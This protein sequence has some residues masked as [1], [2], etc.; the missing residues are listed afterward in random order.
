MKGLQSFGVLGLV[1]AV[2]SVGHA[3]IKSSDFT[4]PAYPQGTFNLA[5]AYP[6]TVGTYASSGI[7]PSQTWG[8]TTASQPLTQGAASGILSLKRT[9]D[10]V[11][12]ANSFVVIPSGQRPPCSIQ[13]Y[14][15]IKEV[16]G[17]YKCP[18]V[19]G[20]PHFDTKNNLTPYRYYQFGA[21][22]RTWWSLSFS[23]PGT[24]FILEVVSVCQAIADGTPRV[25]KD[26][27][28]WRVTANADTLLAVIDLMHGAAI[29]TL[30]V[31]CILGEDMYAALRSAA[32]RL[33]A[34]QSMGALVPIS[35]RLFDLEALVVSNCLF[36]EV[37]RPTLVYPGAL[38]FGEPGF[39]P[40]GNLSQSV[41]IGGEGS[42]IAG[43][44]DT[45]E[46][47][48]CCKLLVDLEWIAIKNGII[49]QTP[50]L[51]VF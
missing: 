48:C 10:F 45:I 50:S 34:A 44:V 51:P 33:K 31:P 41:F 15:L 16:P 6:C 4:V 11:L 1:L 42:A 18:D 47:P 9:D 3:Q 29:S 14:Q 12:D 32:T 19:Y 35:N 27:W 7:S 5:E 25:H 39:Q 36:I 30:E 13:G 22:V 21:G 23:Q 43:M 24:R 38:Q 40:P 37:L 46:N 26:V 20:A 17:S 8:G 49:G 28:V 2:A